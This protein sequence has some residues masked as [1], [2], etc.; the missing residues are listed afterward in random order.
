MT[1]YECAIAWRDYLISYWP[2]GRMPTIHDARHA[3]L[4]VDHGDGRIGETYPFK[5]PT[6]D[7][8]LR[9]APKMR[10]TLIAA[11]LGDEIALLKIALVLYPCDIY[12][13]DPYGLRGSTLIPYQLAYA[14]GGNVLSAS[15]PFLPTGITIDTVPKTW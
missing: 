5:D 3:G 10:D 13:Y 4:D 1:V 2:S 14:A 7:I 6:K 15:R 11:S 8:V 9:P 12:Q